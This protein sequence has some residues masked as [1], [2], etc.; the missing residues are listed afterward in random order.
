MGSVKAIIYC[1]HCLDEFL[2]ILCLSRNRQSTDG[3]YIAKLSLEELNSFYEQVAELPCI[4]K[5]RKLLKVCNFLETK[6]Y[7]ITLG[8]VVSCVTRA[9]N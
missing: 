4:I 5:E 7:R 9:S 6:I 1:L 2:S 8:V 3:K